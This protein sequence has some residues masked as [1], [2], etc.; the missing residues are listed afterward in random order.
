MA[1]LF[2]HKLADLKDGKSQR[3]DGIHVHEIQQGA[4]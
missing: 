4:L 3:V 1:P 2:Q